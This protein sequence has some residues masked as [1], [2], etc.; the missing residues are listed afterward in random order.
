MSGFDEQVRA[1]VAKGY[2]GLFRVGEE[3]F[4][5]GLEPLRAL[6]PPPAAEGPDRI[7]FVL[8]MPAVPVAA[9]LER[10][11][12]GGRAGFVSADAADL[13]TYGP[14]TGVEVP[15]GPYLLADV[16]R[17]DA[18]ANW[19]PD[20]ALPA[21]TSRG[22]T[23][24]TIAE[25]VALLTVAPELLEKNRCFMMLA[26]R[27]RDKRVPALWICG[28]TGRDGRERRGAP[29]LGWCWAGNRHTWLGHASAGARI[30]AAR[31][32]WACPP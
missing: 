15:A 27:G 17:G 11:V 23:P 32:G 10:V 26:S 13:H 4:A 16:E 20:Q 9:A 25:G 14:I 6:V 21:I 3:E 29:K 19:S 30:G 24:L 28:G 5:A 12:V 31:S 2:P 8:V 7:S 18:Y 1:Y 22:R